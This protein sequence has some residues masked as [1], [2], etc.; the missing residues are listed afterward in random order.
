MPRRVN[1]AERGPC[2]EELHMKKNQVQIG[3]A[4]VAKVSGKLATVRIDAE[5]RHGG[6]E[7]TNVDTGRNVRIKSAQRLRREVASEKTAEPTAT[8]TPVD[9]RP[10]QDI[11]ERPAA[12]PPSIVPY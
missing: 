11:D 5:S 10:P 6:W 8:E 9:D 2:R 4:F 1:A 12:A 7:A 3:G